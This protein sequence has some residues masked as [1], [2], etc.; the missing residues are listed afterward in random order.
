MSTLEG[1][2]APK[3]A[4]LGLAYKGNVDDVRESPALDVVELLRETLPGAVITAYEPHVE[5]CA[6]CPTAALHDV[7]QGADAAVLLTPHDEYRLLDPLEL[8]P[9]MRGKLLLDTHNFLDAARWRSAG[10]RTVVRGT[11]DMAE[12]AP[13]TAGPR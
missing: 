2:A 9:L 7:F 1:R 8:G 12:T 4:V 5:S 6:D 11:A 13:A 3:I 10:F